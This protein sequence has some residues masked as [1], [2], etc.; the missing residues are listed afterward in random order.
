MRRPRYGYLVEK[1][2]QAAIASIEV[3]N[4]PG[5]KYR[6]ETFAILMLNAWELLLK[7]RILKANRSKLRSIEVWEPKTTKKG[8]G[9]RLSPK[10][11][12][13]GNTMTIGVPA[14]T[15]PLLECGTNW[16]KPV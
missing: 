9:K 5:F 15:L 3:Y 8:S 13:A 1:A 7:A 4:K 14:G 6:E 12:R 11:N 10:K 2:T 16:N